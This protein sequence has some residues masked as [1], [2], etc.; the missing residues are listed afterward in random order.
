MDSCM[1]R[2]KFAIALVVSGI[3]LAAFPV[4]ARRRGD[5]KGPVDATV[6]D[7]LDGDTFL[8]EAHVWPGQVIEINIRVR[9]IDAPEMKSRCEAERVAA[10]KA[11]DALAD[12]VG[13]SV[14]I[15]NIGSAKYYGRVLADV[16]TPDGDRVAEHMLG[17]ALGACPDTLG[18]VLFH[19]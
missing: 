12:L 9:G 17:R 10:L 13:E 2:S 7:V 15:S 5:F 19:E 6:V 4:D 11:R 14:R 18:M 8:A 1:A 3:M 16:E